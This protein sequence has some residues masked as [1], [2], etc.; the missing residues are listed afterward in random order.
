VL[1]SGNAVDVTEGGSTY[2]LNLDPSENLQ[3]VRFALVPDGMSGTEVTISV[4]LVTGG[5]V[6]TVAAGQT[7]NTLIV[8]SGGMLDVLS[9]GTAINAT[10]SS[11]GSLNVSAGGSALDFTISSGGTANDYGVTTATTLA[12]G[13]EIIYG[14]GTAG[15]TVVSSSGGE[16]Y[17]AAG[18]RSVSATIDSLGQQL[19]Y[20]TAISATV[21]VGGQEFVL[22]GGLASG[23]VVSRAA[24]R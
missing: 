13:L 4:T 12:G 14:G 9:G 10:I 21:S 7:D 6:L 24:S 15:G 23:M 18:A 2:V 22:S 11:G 20:G 19:V 1:N 16:E 17:V 8:L 5:Q 3:G